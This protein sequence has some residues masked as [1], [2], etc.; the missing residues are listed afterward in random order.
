MAHKRY[1]IF[2]IV[3][4]LSS[5]VISA[6]IPLYIKEMFDALPSM[7]FENILL[8][9]FVVL[10]LYTLSALIEMLGGFVSNVAETKA[11]ASLEKTLLSRCLSFPLDYYDTRSKGDVLSIATSDTEPVGRLGMSLVPGLIFNGSSLIAAVTVLLVLDIRIGLLAIATLPIYALPMKIFTGRLREASRKERQEF[12]K[13]VELFKDGLDGVLDLKVY[14]S[15]SRFM[16]RVSRQLDSWIKAIRKL[17]LYQTASYGVQAP[18]SM[19]LSL[20]VLGFAVMLVHEGVVTIGTAIAAYTF[21]YR[22]YTPIIRF[23]FIWSS[24][25]RTVPFVSRVFGLIEEGAE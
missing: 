9:V 2:L 11:A 25:Q 5:T 18:L 7:V 17:A 19:L 24:F 14:S 1:Q 15:V 20:A 22:L 21:L 23:A 8:T 16:E 4:V 13:S 6:L 12:S 3:C 10:L